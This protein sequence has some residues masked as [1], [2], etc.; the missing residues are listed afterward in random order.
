MQ[1]YNNA[2]MIV[3]D[4]V[5]P[6]RITDF[7]EGTCQILGY[8]VTEF[9]RYKRSLKDLMTAEDFR[10]A[11]EAIDFELELSNHISIKLPLIDKNNNKITVLCSGQAFL[12]EDDRTVL[13]CSVTDIT[14]I[15]NAA[16]E[17][18]KA[19]TDLEQ[20]ANSVPCGVS[21]HLL[22]NNLSVIW[23]N[24]SFY[25]LCGYNDL[26]FETAFG[27]NTFMI[28]F[29]PDLAIVIDALA[30]LSVEQNADVNFRIVCK[31]QEVKWVNA[32]LAHSGEMQEGFPVINI[33][34]T[35]IT[36]LKAAEMRA[37]LEQQK[38]E[39]L[40]DIT[41]ELAYEYDLSENIL[42]FAEKFSQIFNME[43]VMTDPYTTLIQ[44]GIVPEESYIPLQQFFRQA[45]EGKEYY[46]AEFQLNSNS[47]KQ[48][49][50]STFSSIRDEFGNPI[51]VIGLLRNIN[52]QKTE[53]KNLL[54]RAESD[55]M[56][57]LLNKTTTEGRIRER[58]RS[59]DT[60]SRDALILLDIDN[61]KKI[62]DS[63]GHLAGDEVI[64]AIADTFR[65]VI[66]QHHIIG[67]TGGDEFTVY[68]TD[69]PDEAYVKHTV[70]QLQSVLNSKFTNRSDGL[71]PTLSIGI[72]MVTQ[73]VSYSD[74]AEQADTALYTTKLKGK[75]GYSIYCADM[76]RQEYINNREESDNA[77]DAEK[78]LNFIEE[79][80]NVL[81]MRQNTY[82]TL[83]K[84]IHMVGTHYNIDRICIWEYPQS[85]TGSMVLCQHLWNSDRTVSNSLLK[86]PAPAIFFEEI[87]KL[88]TN[89]SFYV[90][91]A[92]ISGISMADTIA[93]IQNAKSFIQSNIVYRNKTVGYI[94]FASLDGGEYWS[95]DEIAQYNIIFKMLS[96]TICSKY[97]SDTLNT[98]REDMIQTFDAMD[99]C[100]L[101][102]NAN[103]HEVLYYN[104]AA[105]ELFPAIT[106]NCCCHFVI[107]QEHEPCFECPIKQLT[108]NRKRARMTKLIQSS[109]IE[110][111]V[112]AT[113]FTWNADIKAVL[114]S[115]TITARRK[116]E[117]KTETLSETNKGFENE[118]K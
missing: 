97:M 52:K 34:L 48:W 25:R 69:I 43:P 50:S 101:V 31:N 84:V 87:A 23:A 95:E 42:T 62:N 107:H 49:Y 36:S 85:D 29:R 102:L 108:E 74:L 9:A 8:P 30:D 88:S 19:K 77:S 105:K 20:F 71:I 72:A 18:V 81:Y 106:A 116:L 26:E 75:N 15:E 47:G 17:T 82:Q 66:E 100:I 83:E 65:E 41:E 111:D 109:G 110:L 96:E 56:T 1:A 76:V 78:N 91:D 70:L 112:V 114:L 40:S 14:H 113:P 3:I 93:A 80:I 61:F 2:G 53:Q 13:Q 21:K 44:K 37:A 99:N 45:A 5:I 22:D 46:S 10:K 115:A 89:G 98:F 39:I 6:Y 79:L 67:R 68:L 86:K 58:L 32:T 38:Y 27:R 24:R 51:R 60:N 118:Q 117:D 33:I 54:L 90:K 55:L 28:I 94:T 92:R 63:Y 59:I 4:T 7:D 64:H 73:T 35:D 16:N 103:S 11:M 12:A 57:G 104:P